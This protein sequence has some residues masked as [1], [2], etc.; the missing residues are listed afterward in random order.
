MALG[1]DGLEQRTADLEEY[2]Y[3]ELD[4][5]EI[6]ERLADESRDDPENWS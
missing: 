4:R 1:P 3:D 2:F 5:C 6:S